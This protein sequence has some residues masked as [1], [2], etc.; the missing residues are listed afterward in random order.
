MESLSEGKKERPRT[1]M[2]KRAPAHPC[3]VRCSIKPVSK[4]RFQLIIIYRGSS[5]YVNFI[6][7]N[8]ITAIFQNSVLMESLSEG[9]KER[10]HTGTRTPLHSAVQHKACFKFQILAESCLWISKDTTIYVRTSLM[11]LQ[12]HRFW[13]LFLQLAAEKKTPFLVQLEKFSALLIL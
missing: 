3:P 7:A 13:C 1:S 10:A 9:K 12:L 5:S 2:R 8:L 11:T 6:T 4:F